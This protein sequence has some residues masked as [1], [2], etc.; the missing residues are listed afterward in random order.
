MIDFSSFSKAEKVQYL[1]LLKERE[2]RRAQDNPLLALRASLFKQQRALFDDKSRYKAAVCS[3]R[4]GKS[5]YASIELLA[6]ALMHPSSFA[7]YLGLNRQV[8]KEIMWDV[9]KDSAKEFEIDVRW[10][11]SE[12]TGRLQNGSYVK[13]IGADHKRVVEA[14]RGPKRSVAIIDEAGSFSR[15]LETLID[16]ALEPSLADLGGPIVLLGTPPPLLGGY[17][18]EK[19]IRHKLYS[20]HHWTLLD[21][22][23]MPNAKEWLEELKKKRNWSDDNPTYRR[24]YLGEFVHDD[25][26][27]VYK[28]RKE[29]DT[30]S[31]AQM[32]Q[33][34]WQ[35]V[36]GLD[37]GWND[38]T[39]I[40]LIYYH[41][42][43]PFAYVVKANK[44]RGYTVHRIAQILQELMAREKPER[45]IADTGGLGKMICEELKQRYNLPI[46]A[47]E[48]TE[49]M[50]HI[51][52]INSDYREGRLK[53]LDTLHDLIS[54][55]ET[56]QWDDHQKETAGQEN[57]LC[58]AVLYPWRFSYHYWH[59]ETPL[60]PRPGTEAYALKQ[61]DDML[62]NVATEYEHNKQAQ[63]LD[64]GFLADDSAI[65]G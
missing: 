58:D 52:L 59:Q 55:Y 9:L 15:L 41:P 23:Y 47:A 11:E 1:Q 29:R 48:K 56:L 54:Q 32:P 14:L 44:Y 22:P 24:E 46:T 20:Y 40:S 45:I 64:Y 4:A 63:E 43:H 57:D 33:M 42:K 10:H 6:R 31:V 28:F 18:Y 19:T 35:K 25:A 16:D 34:Q 49:K 26:A 27:R 51:E 12:L 7:L 38:A 61:E 37:L 60:Q 3:R 21:N 53:V 2:R 5:R 39:A 30:V 13:V 50:A 65:F 8:S 17:F 36:V 62:K